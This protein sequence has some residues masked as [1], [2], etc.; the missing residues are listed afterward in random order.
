MEGDLLAEVVAGEGQHDVEVVLA[1]VAEEHVLQ[2]AAGALVRLQKNHLAFWLA[3]LVSASV[4]A[5]RGTAR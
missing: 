5:S 3:P 4:R 2:C 1:G